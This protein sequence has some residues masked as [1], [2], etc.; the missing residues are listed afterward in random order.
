[1]ASIFARRRTRRS[2]LV[3]GFALS[4]VL[5]WMVFSDDAE[6]YVPGEQTDGLTDSL[7]RNLPDD[8][9]SIRLVE[10][11]ESAGLEFVHFPY[12]RSNRLPE[13]M[14]AGVALGDVDGDGFT[15]V[16]L[17]N[18]HPEAVEAEPGT[19]PGTEAACRLF[20]N[21]GDGRLVDITETSGAGLILQGFAAVFLDREG[22]G[23]LDLMVSSLGSCRLL[24]NDGAGH[25]SDVSAEAGL[26]AHQGFWTGL[27]SGDVDGDDDV[28]VY[29]CGYVAYDESA[30]NAG[31]LSSQFGLDIP[32]LIN[33]SAFESERNL[34]L[35]N[36]GTGRFT[37]GAQAAGVVNPGGR[38][39]GA[40]IADFSGDGLPD[41]YVANDV[42]DNALYINRG[43]GR[44]EDLTTRA[45]VGDY[46]GAMG[47]AVGDVDGDLDPDL[48]ITHWVGQE[49][50]LYLNLAAETAEQ[51][52][53]E[54]LFMDMAD[55]HGLGQVALPM[56]GWG[57]SLLDLDSDGRLDLHVVNG[58]TIPER[59]DR[60]LLGAQEDHV[61]WNAGPKRGFF[62]LGAFAGESFAE[63]TVGR[64]S[65]RFDLELDGDPDL[66]VMVHGDRPLLLRNDTPAAAHGRLV[67]RPRQPAGN[68]QAL[69]A[70]VEL[71]ADGHRQV[72][73]IGS[74]GS[75][76]SQHAV[77]EAAFGL[78]AATLVD[79][80]LITWPDGTTETKTDV[81]ADQLL[82]WVR[83]QE[84][85][86]A[87]LP[88][89]VAQ[90]RV[91]AGAPPTDPEQRRAFHR[92]LDE[93]A[94]ARIAGN[95]QAALALY[96][97]ALALWPGHDDG[98][99]YRANCLLEL[100]REQEAVHLFE[101]LV[102][103]HPQSNRAWMQLGKLR[104]PGG[105]PACD[106]LATARDAFERAHT[107][108]GEE[109]GPVLHLAL[110]DLLAGELAAAREGFEH[111]ARTNARDVPSR[112]FAGYLAWTQ[113][114]GDAATKWLAEA[115]TAAAG[116]LGAGNSPS[117]EGDTKT[118]K[119]LV[120]SV[121]PGTTHPVLDRW[122]SVLVREGAVDEEY[123]PVT[124][125]LLGETP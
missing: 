96:G 10:V 21:T 17:V 23:D 78:G 112:Y 114:E 117:S 11:G 6:T 80:L 125:A 48:F 32:S 70:R 55:R 28:D 19:K 25:F 45:L 40:S 86:L 85:E 102:Q 74:Q 51:Q 105:D 41:L 108:N 75:Y 15:D 7:R 18:S 62:Q 116:Q 5:A 65:A 24:D 121:G 61:F 113:G 37:D 1:M 12:E 44:F 72:R 109:S 87:W 99:Y 2:L 115:R 123:G 54:I 16:F 33:P 39:L 100:G 63:E 35:L 101:L 29:V 79:E 73:W 81:P 53:A 47:L 104:L 3:S 94:D 77:G 111:A 52:A 83:G 31:S 66:V 95:T 58:H 42:S 124:E 84:P 49:N 76:L 106:D 4:G 67:V 120:A 91:S 93:A 38:S 90:W 119:A 97:E 34:L 43:D 64:G 118:G 46:R 26:D 71:L 82:T 92:L 59:D 50:A 20:R 22:D 103:L 122:R 89:R 36:D 69:G 9:P 60:S 56:V 27:A 30:V 107:I 110:A 13:D 88:G 14:G 8:T 57:S 98:T 68:T